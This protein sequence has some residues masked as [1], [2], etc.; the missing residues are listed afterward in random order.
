MWKSIFSGAT[1]LIAAL[2]WG[3]STQAVEN[4]LNQDSLPKFRVRSL[5]VNYNALRAGETVLN[6]PRNG[7]EIQ[8][9][10]AVHKFNLTF[11]YGN[12]K[13]ERGADYSYVSDGTYFR[14]GIDVNMSANWQDGN[15]VGMGLRYGQAMF[16]EQAVFTKSLVDVD[17]N[18]FFEQNIDLSNPKTKAQWGELVFKM[19]GVIWKNFYTGY[20]MRLQFAMRTDATDSELRSFDIPGYG[21]TT[22]NNSF[23]FDYYVG[24]RFNFD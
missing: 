7:Q 16:D 15:M 13:S 14:A 21:K 5:S 22:K 18:T 1:L 20:T 19:R 8:G 12:Q 23:G 11:D 6:K 3:Q 2:S 10:L 4:L 9:E 24:W 17:G